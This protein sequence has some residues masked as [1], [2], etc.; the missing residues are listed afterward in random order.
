V[1]FLERKDA[2][3]VI[4]PYK[5]V[6]LKDETTEMRDFYEGFSCGQ[7][8]DL[9]VL[10]GDRLLKMQALAFRTEVWRKLGRKIPEHCFYTDSEYVFYSLIHSSTVTFFDKPIYR[11]FLQFE[12]QSVSAVGIRKHFRDTETVMWDLFDVYGKEVLSGGPAE[13]P[14]DARRLPILLYLLKHMASFVYTAYVVAGKKQLPALRKINARMEKEYPEL[15]RL[16]GEVRRI[17]VM[18]RS[19]LRFYHLYTWILRKGAE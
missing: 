13:G 3:L 9:S 16:T 4:R 2:D 8:Y 7:V 19:G 15:Y 18:R 17:G 5:E 10:H 14:G 11:Y 6:Y 12:G 1:D